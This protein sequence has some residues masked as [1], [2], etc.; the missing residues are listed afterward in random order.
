V[1]P[2]GKKR[3]GHGLS[4]KKGGTALGGGPFASKGEPEEKGK[5]LYYT[6][7]RRPEGRKKSPTL[8]HS[9]PE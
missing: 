4:N 1:R 6:F 5:G 2:R 7:C 8:S 9:M 3:K